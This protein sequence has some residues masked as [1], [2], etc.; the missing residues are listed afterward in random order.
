MEYN[1]INID[2]KKL[3][4]KVLKEYLYALDKV[5]EKYPKLIN[6]IDFIGN[7]ADSFKLTEK[8]TEYEY[9]SKTKYTFW[10]KFDF[11]M[12]SYAFS[13]LIRDPDADK[14]K[15]VLLCINEKLNYDK[16]YKLINNCLNKNLMYASNIEQLLYHEV[17]HMFSGLFKLIKKE[18]LFGR[19]FEYM[20]VPSEE[21]SS[22]SLSSFEEF[23]A[24]HFSMYLINPTFNEPTEFIGY[25]VD[26]YYDIYSDTNALSK[27]NDMHN[28]ILKK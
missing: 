20:C 25:M 10:Q 22:Y 27:T 7:F 6:R 26:K 21:F 17:G 4:S 28:L 3:D 12:T 1:G 23:I 16:V 13:S 15:Y 9:N 11:Y 18:D 8:I 19:V 2:D 14:V 5:L 24:E